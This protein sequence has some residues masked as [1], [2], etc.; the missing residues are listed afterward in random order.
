MTPPVQNLTQEFEYNGYI[1]RINEQTFEA[2][3]NFLDIKA[4]HGNDVDATK[5]AAFRTSITNI[6]RR[7]SPIY[8]ELC[9]WKA[10]NTKAPIKVS[11]ALNQTSGDTRIIQDK[12]A[13][14][15]KEAT[16]KA[17]SIHTHIELEYDALKQEVTQQ[18]NYLT[19]RTT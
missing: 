1:K 12:K 19:Q 4:E 10:S 13:H 7:A 15:Q 2:N 6:E 17:K 5:L 9:T 16:E 8:A 3:T 11:P 14:R 18:G